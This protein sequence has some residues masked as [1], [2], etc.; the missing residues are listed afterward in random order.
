M[1]VGVNSSKI[2]LISI[3]RNSPTKGAFENL[4]LES[5]AFRKFDLLRKL[6]VERGFASF[7]SWVLGIA[8]LGL[9]M[10]EIEEIWV[11][12]VSQQLA[13]IS[14]FGKGIGWQYSHAVAGGIEQFDNWHPEQTAIIPATVRIRVVVKCL[15]MVF[16]YS[17][18]S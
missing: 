11:E 6:L 17:N 14:M 3:Y 13:R 7:E 18:R 15:L 8:E 1:K 9:S 4:R 5:I 12:Q 10:L 16:S 2:Q